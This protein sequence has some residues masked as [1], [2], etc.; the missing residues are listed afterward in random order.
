[1]TMVVYTVIS[2]GNCSADMIMII[3]KNYLYTVE[4]AQMH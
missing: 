3:D 4:H 2:H 1:M